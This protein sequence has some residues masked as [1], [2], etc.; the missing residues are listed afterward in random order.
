[1]KGN[2]E[3]N[4]VITGLASLFTDVS[5]EMIYPIISLYLRALG[6]GPFI[7]GTIEGIAESTASLLKVFSGAIADWSG[8][9]KPLTILGYAL[10]L[11]GKVLFYFAHGWPTILGGRFADRFGKGIRTAPRDAMISE[12]VSLQAQGKA[13]GLHRTFDT[14]GA[15]LGVLITYFFVAQI[16]QKA[17]ASR[18]LSLYLPTFRFIIFLSLIPAILGVLVLFFALETGTG[19]KMHSTFSLRLHPIQRLNHKLKVFFLATLIFTLGNSSNQ[20]ILLRAAEPD[21]GISPK[22]VI[23]LYFLYNLVYMLVS[24]PAGKLSDRIGRK[25][26][27]VFGFFLYSLSYFLIGVTPRL[28]F[29]IMVPYGLHI[30]MTEGV[31]KALVAELSSPEEKATILGLHATLLGIGLF[32]ASLLAG[33]LWNVWGSASPFLFGGSASLLATMIIAFFL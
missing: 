23:L 21:I 16:Q 2:R 6:G 24:Y 13:F 27:L 12:S 26:L 20:F 14:L 10:S 25:K 22:N 28:I 31:S 19:N 15:L 33:W 29:W 11:L 30:G 17:A 8:K 1:M 9:R 5:S 7:L 32:P 4:I 18:E 3:R